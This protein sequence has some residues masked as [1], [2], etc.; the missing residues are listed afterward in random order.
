M[1]PDQ[2]KKIIRENIKYIIADLMMISVK[3]VEVDNS[4]S[5]IEG[6]LID[7]VSIV[8]LI[9]VCCDEFSIDIEAEDLTIEYWDNINSIADFIHNKIIENSS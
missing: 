3:E 2:I 8:S 7:S 1:K 4:D 6:G 5:L 9:E